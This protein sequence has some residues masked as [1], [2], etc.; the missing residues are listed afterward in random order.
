[1]PHSKAIRL[2]FLCAFLLSACAPGTPDAAAAALALKA[3]SLDK[4]QAVVETAI[5]Q[6]A[7][8]PTAT[9]TDTPTPSL[10]PTTT[11]TPTPAPTDTPTAT[12]TPPM[13]LPGVYDFE[14]VCTSFPVKFRIKTT[15]PYT[16][17]LVFYDAVGTYTFCV[18]AA[19]VLEDRRLALLISYTAE[20]DKS[21]STGLPRKPF[22][23]GNDKVYLTDDQGNRYDAVSWAGD[24]DLTSFMDTGIVATGYFPP[25]PEGIYT[26]TFHD[27]EL[28]IQSQPFTLNNRSEPP[29]GRLGFSPFRFDP[30]Q[31]AGFRE[32]VG[33]DGRL[34][35]Y[36]MAGETCALH[37]IH[38]SQFTED[39]TG[40]QSYETGRFELGLYPGW[41]YTKI[42][43]RRME[44]L[45][46]TPENRLA[47]DVERGEI[48]SVCQYYLLPLIENGLLP[49]EP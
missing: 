42:L 46:I 40:G 1:M 41:D 27:E 7:A 45:D 25:S 33:S 20:W 49:A 22:L 18:H 30:A 43:V 3:A 17:T 4:T 2:I 21:A 14:D 26:F 9:A 38:P 10:T 15:H 12:P 5:A 11:P 34:H 24:V 37:E 23:D 28:N 32:E 19:T 6:T 47:F 35:L 31:L 44:G 36:L 39:L 8:A 29:T 16:G 48:F 13:V